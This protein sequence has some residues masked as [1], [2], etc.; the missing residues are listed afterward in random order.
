MTLRCNLFEQRDHRLF[1]VTSS[2]VTVI[3]HEPMDRRDLSSP[4]LPH[5]KA[6]HRFVQ[7]DTK[8]VRCNIA[9]SLCERTLVR[10]NQGL[11]VSSYIQCQTSRFVAGRT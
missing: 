7:H 3:D 9:P 4:R 6:N 8:W 2:L 11:L 1:A 10:C 5:R